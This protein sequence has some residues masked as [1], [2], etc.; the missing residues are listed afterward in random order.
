M[1]LEDAEDFAAGDT[2]DKGDTVL[3]TEQDADL[4]RHLS[5]LRCL[6]DHLLHLPGDNTR[7]RTK[8][9]FPTITNQTT[10]EWNGVEGEEKALT[11]EAAVFSQVG[12][13]L[14][15]GSADDEIPFLR[16]GAT[17]PPSAHRFTTL[18]AIPPVLRGRGQE[19]YPRLCIRPMAALECTIR[20][21]ASWRLQQRRRRE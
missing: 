18:E 14:L 9:A 4:R 19:G 16:H 2:L 11:S 6:C 17:Q 12:G 15:Y 3:V 7:Q 20:T 1:G 8:S 5:L 13:V 10:A 21:T